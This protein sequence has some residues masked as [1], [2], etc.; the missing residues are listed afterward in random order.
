MKRLFF[1]YIFP[2][3]VLMMSF[4][5]K[6]QNMPVPLELQ[7]P[8]VSTPEYLANLRAYKKTKHQIAFGWLG[9][10]GGD[11]KF[12]SLQKR[13]E[14]VPDSLD[15]VSLWGGI[16][17]AGSPQMAA[18]RSAQ[19][20]R[21]IKVVYVKFADDD[22]IAP[23]EKSPNGIKLLAKALA[24]TLTKNNIDG[25]DIDYEPNVGGGSW[26]FFKVKSNMT[27]LLKEL[28][29]FM[30]PKAGT[31]KLLIVDGEVNYLEAAAGPLLDYA[32]AQAYYTTNA[33]GLQSRYNAIAS[34]CPPE[35]FI[36]TEDFEAGWK[37]GGSSYQ[38]AIYGTIPSLIGMAYWQP[39][40]GRK[41]GAGTYH[42]EYEYANTPDYKYLRQ[43]IQIMN[44]AVH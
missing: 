16:P 36:V 28:S 26:T 30:G 33:A 1:N 18:M 10:S 2:S 7:K 27:L 38:D 20:D 41:G 4:S 14:G 29:A 8:F 44:P 9:G 5:C 23:F 19:T 43:A 25:F 34:W 40:Q 42:M 35:K 37:T 32:I 15:I 6:K 24:D 21:G 22:L 17:T 31:G 12:A 39:T 3:F 13:W 11:G